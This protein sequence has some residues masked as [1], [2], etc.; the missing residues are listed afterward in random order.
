MTLTREQLTAALSYDPDTGV[1]TR[2]IN[3]RRAKAGDIAGH[4]AA[5]GR[6][7]IRVNSKRFLAHRLAWLYM[8]GEWPVAGVDHKDVNPSNNRWLN[9]RQAN[10]SQNMHNMH[11]PTHNT[12]GVKG[13]CFDKENEK[14]MAYIYVD[15]RFKNLGR[16][17]EKDDAAAAYA[18]AAVALFGEFARVTQTS[19]GKQPDNLNEPRP[20]YRLV[21]KHTLLRS[22]KAPHGQP[23]LFAG[24]QLGERA[25]TSFHSKE[26]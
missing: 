2:R 9:L 15:G 11:A 25:A 24:R 14:W 26:H 5:D 13:V 3:S 7:S 20:A 19:A 22:S 23:L 4:H 10:Q 8:T 17:T 6:V 16:F 18:K 1:F 21:C 12:S